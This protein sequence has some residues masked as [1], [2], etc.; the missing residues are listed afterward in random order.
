MDHAVQLT[1]PGEPVLLHIAHGLKHG[2]QIGFEALVASRH[3]MQQRTDRH[4]PA[5]G[6]FQQVVNTRRD[7]AQLLPETYWGSFL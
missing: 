1:L 4:G 7:L 3:P 2:G 5:P 6:G